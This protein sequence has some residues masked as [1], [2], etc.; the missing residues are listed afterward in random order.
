[1]ST[2]LLS[3]INSKNSTYKQSN[4]K[5]YGFLYKASSIDEVKLYLKN[6]KEQFPDASHICYA[7]RLFNGYNLLKDINILEYNTDAGEPRGS[8]GPPILKA[9]KQ[10]HLINSVIFIVRY[11]GGK[12]LGIPGLIEAYSNASKLLI[13]LKQLKNWF[14]TK[15]MGLEYPYNLENTLNNLFKKFDVV[16]KKQKFQDLVFTFIEI[17]EF[18]FNEFTAEIQKLPTC[19]IQ[20]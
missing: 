17:N 7:Y 18:E 11:F 19:K 13:D 14:P 12:K 2:D 16:I 8:S 6:L 9:L 5:F 3:P 4:S 1:V 15:S 10:F 20:N